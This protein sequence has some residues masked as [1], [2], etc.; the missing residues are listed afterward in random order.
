MSKSSIWSVECQLCLVLFLNVTIFHVI[1]D[2][3]RSPLT[4]KVL[5]LLLSFRGFLFVTL[6]EMNIFECY[7]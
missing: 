1:A 6:G 5:H 2:P 7:K 3:K 4:H